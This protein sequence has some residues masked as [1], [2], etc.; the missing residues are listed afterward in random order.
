MTFEEFKNMVDGKADF[1]P[2]EE[3]EI[4]SIDFDDLEN[5][6]QKI[7]SPGLKLVRLLTYHKD[8]SLETFKYIYERH[9]RV[10]NISRHI[11]KHAPIFKHLEAVAFVLDSSIDGESIEKAISASTKNMV[12]A[13]I[14][15]KNEN[16]NET[17]K[18]IYGLYAYRMHGDDTYLTKDV[19]DLF[20]F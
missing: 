12:N 8:C 5:W 3:K 14:L 1:T 18:N 10:F 11:F 13:D 16:I 6:T 15:I 2:K 9:Q 7:N 17:F 20:V 4:L 19:V